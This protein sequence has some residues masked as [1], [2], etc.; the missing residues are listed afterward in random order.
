M[1][2]STQRLEKTAEAMREACVKLLTQP[3][4]G[5]DL[6]RFIC[7]GETITDT[8]G[9]EL[10]IAVADVEKLL[11]KRAKEMRGIPLSAELTERDAG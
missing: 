4:T 9:N 10:F 6:Q 8:N 5:M 11:N 7:N 1:T 2:I 3:I